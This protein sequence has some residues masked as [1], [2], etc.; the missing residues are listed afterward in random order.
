MKRNTQNRRRK[1]T[2]TNS[3]LGIVN[4]AVDNCLIRK[5]RERETEMN[6]TISEGTDSHGC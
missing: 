2:K 4:G 6:N 1:V 5:E 3:A